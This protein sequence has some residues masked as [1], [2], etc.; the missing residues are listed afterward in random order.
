MLQQ[1]VLQNDQLRD[2]SVWP[3]QT[4]WER[5]KDTVHVLVGSFE[6]DASVVQ[7]CVTTRDLQDVSVPALNQRA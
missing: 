4:S 2:L 3:V 7:A 1:F 6:Y 5:A